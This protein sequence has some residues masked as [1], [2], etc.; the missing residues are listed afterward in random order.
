MSWPELPAFLFCDESR[1]DDDDR[2]FVFHTQQPRFLMEFVP[3]GE[4][5]CLMIDPAPEDVV[6]PLRAQARDFF[7]EELDCQSRGSTIEGSS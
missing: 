4:G 2:M 3:G 6:A 7:N 1:C 5:E